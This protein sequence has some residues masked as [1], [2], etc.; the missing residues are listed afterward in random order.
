[1]RSTY[2]SGVEVA[3]AGYIFARDD[4]QYRKWKAK[5]GDPATGESGGLT[6]MALEQHIAS[7]QR[8]RPDL[9]AVRT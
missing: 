5:A 9:V 2:E 7:L 1:M 4:K 6:G 3:R 8:S